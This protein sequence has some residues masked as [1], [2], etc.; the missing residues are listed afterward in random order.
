[1]PLPQASTTCAN[2]SDLRILLLK[3]GLLVFKRHTN[4]RKNMPTSSGGERTSCIMP[5]S[6]LLGPPWPISKIAS[7]ASGGNALVLEDM[8]RG[9]RLPLAAWSSG[10]KRGVLNGAEGWNG[11]RGRS[12]CR[13][14]WG[15]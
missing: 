7:L 9:R 13:W 4:K 6:A 12:S 5:S 8:L 14:C 1:M 3:K 10:V 11:D 2:L 15:R